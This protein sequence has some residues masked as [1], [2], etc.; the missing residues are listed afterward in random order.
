MTTLP[1]CLLLFA[2]RVDGFAA[3]QHFHEG[4]DPFVPGGFGFDVVEA[5]G[6]GEAVLGAE[7]G[8]GGGGLGLS[9][10][11]GLEGGGDLHLLAALVGT[12]PAAI[13]FG[14]LDVFEAVR[15]HAA[16]SDEAG[17][18]VDIDLAPDAFAATGSIPLEVA[19]FVEAFADGV[20]PAPAKDNVDGLFGGD[21]GEAGVHFVNLDPE[22]ILGVVVLAEPGVEAGRVG[23]FTDS[24]GV[25]GDGRHEGDA[26]I[27]RRSSD[28]GGLEKN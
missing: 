18:V 19:L 9:V 14:G 12:I 5:E 25:D 21:G 15:G 10:D 2:L 8:E 1:H 20:D 22:F 23:E 26:S 24:G 3:L 17:D 6:E 7:G 28:N 27:W 16:L 13:S 4:E 11:G